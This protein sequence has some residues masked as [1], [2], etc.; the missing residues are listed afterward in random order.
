MAEE[1]KIENKGN[2]VADFAKEKAKE[3]GQNLLDKCSEQGKTCGKVTVSYEID[4][5]PKSEQ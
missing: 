1:K 3:L 4:N 5:N 2:V